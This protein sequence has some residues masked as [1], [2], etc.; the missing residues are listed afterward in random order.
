MQ[1]NESLLHQQ[2][3]LHTHSTAQPCLGRVFNEVFTLVVQ[4]H[5]TVLKMV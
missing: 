3:P 2:K 1:I 5:S 4:T